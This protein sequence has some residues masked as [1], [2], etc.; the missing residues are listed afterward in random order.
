MRTDYDKCKAIEEFESW[1]RGYDESV[2]QKL[3][4]EPTHDILMQYLDGVRVERI[5]DVG[6]GTG[7]FATRLADEF[8][9]ANVWGVDLSLH[10]LEKGRERLNGLSSRLAY[11]NGD[12]EHLPFADSSFDVITCNHSFHHYPNQQLAI[13]EMHRVLKPDGHLFIVDAYTDSL[14]GKFIFD[15]CVVAVEGRVS[16]CSARKFRRLL[17]RGGFKEIG[18]CVK[19]WRLV[20]FLVTMASADKPAVSVPEPCLCV[21]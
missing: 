20:P 9:E 13:R 10:M 5:L 8:P 16:H 18:Q 4:F 21:A 3:L 1:S 11:V 2:V 19:G 7:V 12:S 6:S 14:W 15:V 17:A